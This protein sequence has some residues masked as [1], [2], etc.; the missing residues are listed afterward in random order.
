MVA[1]LARMT[2]L[3]FICCS[4]IFFWSALIAAQEDEKQTRALQVPHR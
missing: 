2:D 4:S 3:V 1:K